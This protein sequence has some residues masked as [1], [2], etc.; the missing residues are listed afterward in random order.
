MN[1]KELL[2]EALLYARK[3]KNQ[4]KNIKIAVLGGKLSLQHFVMVLRYML[5]IEGIYADIYEGEYDGIAMD[6]LDDDSALYTFS[7]EIII[8][9][10]HYNDIRFIPECFDER[11]RIDELIKVSI[12]YYKNIW[13][14]LSRIT[15]CTILQSNIV[16]PDEH[17]LGNLESFSEFSKTSFLKSINEQL[18]LEKYDNVLIVDMEQL[19]CSIGKRNWF[20]YSSY[21]MSKSAFALSNIGEVCKVFIRQI[22]ALKAKVRK[23]LVLDLDNTLWG[24]VIGDDGVDGIQLDP[25]N[26]I[27]EA[28]RNFQQYVLELKKRGVILAICSKN[29]EQIAKEPFISNNNM[30][31]KLDDISCFV[32]NWEDKASNIRTIAQQ[33]N[34]GLDSLVFFDDNPAEREIVHTFLPDVQVID[35]PEDPAL[36]ANTLDKESPF[37]WIQLTKEDILRNN[38]YIQNR[39]RR[40]LELSYDDYSGY[41]DALNMQGLVKQV[42]ESDVPRFCQLLNKTNQFNLRTQR[43]TEEQIH[44]MICDEN[45]MCLNVSLR[46]RF[47]DYGVISCVI[48]RKEESEDLAWFI[49]SWVMSCRVLKRGVEEFTF[50]NVLERLGELGAKRV[51][52]EYIP[53]PKNEMVSDLY[54]KFGFDKILSTDTSV[55]YEYSLDKTFHVDTHI[56][57]GY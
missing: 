30:I 52:G 35:V 10:T 14:K 2:K 45:Y 20:D 47:S 27:G 38:T 31:L 18:Y 50:M 12:D 40:E 44:S 46:D 23:C 49:E 42:T 17:I 53:T 37:E 51:K 1:V 43:Y 54:S 3:A 32:A 29:E 48:L 26:A 24:G 8:I 6:V 4:E 5:S 9:L 55:M 13:H 7:P 21:F 56:G 19:A 41:L 16:L 15:N 34:I 36:Y 11:A 33:L 28:Y 22:L 25:N 57:G 39:A